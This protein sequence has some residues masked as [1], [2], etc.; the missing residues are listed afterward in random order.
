MENES[1]NWVDVYSTVSVPPEWNSMITKLALYKARNA[2]LTFV[3]RKHIGRDVNE[4]VFTDDA[5]KQYAIDVW[6]RICE[7]VNQ[8]VPQLPPL[9]VHEIM[10]LFAISVLKR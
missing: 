8:G 5:L 2:L 4:K 10:A 1:V 7:E 3:V 9:C 6:H